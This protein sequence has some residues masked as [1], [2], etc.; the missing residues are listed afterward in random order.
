[1]SYNANPLRSAAPVAPYLVRYRIQHSYC[2]LP[3]GLLNDTSQIRG[4]TL[5][6]L[7]CYFAFACGSDSVT[8]SWSSVLVSVA[9]QCL[10]ANPLSTHRLAL[11]LS[12]RTLFLT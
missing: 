2:L 5:L 1:L 9:E 7:C 4:L 6:R 10:G 12:F 8:T 11:C 3:C